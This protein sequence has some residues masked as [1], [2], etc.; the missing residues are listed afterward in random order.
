MSKNEHMSNK[1]AIATEKRRE[2]PRLAVVIAVTACAMWALAGLWHNLIVPSFYARAGHAS[3]EGIFVLLLSYVVLAG[4]MV[5][6]HRRAP[7]S[8]R[9]G[10][11][12]GFLFGALIGILWV[13][14]HELA[15]AASHDS[16]FAYVFQ[17]AAWH[18]VEQGWGGVVLIACSRRLAV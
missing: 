7:A 12:S 17:N 5:A 2:F 15:M 11:G 16:S 6:L 4:I 3:H 10:Y 18:V 9:G 1:E 8:G 14:P 13:F